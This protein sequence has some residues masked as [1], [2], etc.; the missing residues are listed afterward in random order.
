MMPPFF[1]VFMLSILSLNC[2]AVWSII[3]CCVN[4]DLMLSMI[5]CFVL[6]IFLFL[7]VTS[8]QSCVFFSSICGCV[9]IS[10]FCFCAAGGVFGSSRGD[11]GG[12]FGSRGDG[13]GVVGCSCGVGGVVMIPVF[14]FVM[15]CFGVLF[16]CLF[17]K[18]FVSFETDVFCRDAR[19]VG[20]GESSGDI[21]FFRYWMVLLMLLMLSG[22]GRL[23]LFCDERCSCCGLMRLSV[24]VGV[25]CAA[26][27]VAYVYGCVVFMHASQNA[28]VVVMCCGVGVRFVLVC[29]AAVVS[30]YVGFV[31]CSCRADVTVWLEAKT[32]PATCAYCRCPMLCG[33]Y[34][35]NEL[36]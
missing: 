6:F 36:L 35:L 8:V 25:V 2:C 11:G 24:Y 5:I 15:S 23:A 14:F 27:A 20:G 10:V 30:A 13:G 33:L 31:L 16:F 18:C 12:A 9:C 17:S 28:C 34:V 32:P 1:S 19:G 7:C 22:G 29:C 26:T 21:V 3:C 4:V